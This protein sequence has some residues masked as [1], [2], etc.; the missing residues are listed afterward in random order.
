M[1]HANRDHVSND[2]VLDFE[3]E[4]LKYD[5]TK[6]ASN[7]NEFLYRIRYLLYKCFQKLGVDTIPNV[8]NVYRKDVMNDQK[9]LF[10]IMMGLDELKWRPYG[11]HSCHNKSVFLFDA[12]PKDYSKIVRF[13]GKYKINY[14]FVTSRQSSNRLSSLMPNLCVR[15][16]PE[17]INVNKYQYLEYAKKTI[18]VVSIGRKW[19]YYHERIVEPLEQRKVVYLY[20]KRKGEIVF[21]DRDSFVKGLAMSKI[22]ICVPSNVTH[23]DRAGDV[24]TMTVRYLESMASKCLV[25]GKAPEEMIDLFGYNPVVEIDLERPVEQIM[26]LLSDYDSYIPLIEKN[27]KEVKE[28]HTWKDRF[29]EMVN[30]WRNV[31]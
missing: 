12:W 8:H 16:V 24:E 2:T 5:N 29:D 11:I 27:Y 26:N 4:I 19:D 10:S 20:E 3:E 31:G 1:I 7:Y 13:C 23:P 18:D 22:S 28:H 14:L 9:H 6:A 17:A 21:P 25:L 30:V 15:Y